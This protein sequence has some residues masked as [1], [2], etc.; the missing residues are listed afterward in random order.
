MINDFST[1]HLYIACD[2]GAESG[3]VMLGIVEAGKITLEE[4]HRF[5]NNPVAIS[6][7]L[8]WNVL[9]IFQELKTG[10]TLTAAHIKKGDL[11]PAESVSVDSWGVDYVMQRG[12]EPLMGLPYHYR[13]T[14]TETTFASAQNAVA[15]ETIFSETGIQFIAFNTLYQLLA[16]KRQDPQLLADADRILLIA[17]YFNFLFSGVANAEVSLASTTQLF[18]PR[19]KSWSSKLLKGFDIPEELLPPVC[20][21]GTI[22]GALLPE[23][24][25]ETGFKNLK[26]IATC[27]HDTGAA[28]AA[29]PAE[30]DCDAGRNW[31]YLSSGTWSLLGIELQEPLISEKARAANFTNEVGYGGTVRFHKNIVGLWIVQECRREW[32]AAGYSWSYEELTQHAGVAEPLK[33]LILPDDPRFA[34]PGQ[35]QYKIKTFCRETGQDVPNTPAQVVRCVLES[36]AMSY[37]QNLEIVQNLT[38]IRVDVLHIVGGGSKNALL[39]QFSANATKTTVLAGPVEATAIG[40]LLLQS[41]ALKHLPSLSSLRE[42]VRNSFFIERFE[43]GDSV[44]WESA[45]E[46]YL[47]LEKP[48]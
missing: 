25:T 4:I 43:P 31:A 28:V 30:P 8:R 24:A 45:Y 17:D 10:L 29:V 47:K 32:Y 48:Q 27:S 40:N 16:Q 11:P 26:V 20:N 33:S 2:L 1:K 36:L 39:N 38:G 22:L 12:S 42:T 23:I 9:S 34:Q 37:R 41:V 35:M 44:A 14:R 6:G 18:N 19:T 5:P 46:R 15:A 7:T 3:R 21:S 13:D